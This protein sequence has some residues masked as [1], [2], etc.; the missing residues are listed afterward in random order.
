MHV[1]S[2]VKHGKGALHVRSRD[3]PRKI[4][5]IRPLSSAGLGVSMFVT[6]SIYGVLLQDDEAIGELFQ[7]EATG[8]ALLIRRHP[9]HGRILVIPILILNVP[10]LDIMSLGGVRYPGRTANVGGGLEKSG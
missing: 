4:V 8:A 7:D 10:A 6:I 1:N 2:V 5:T 9:G 3:V